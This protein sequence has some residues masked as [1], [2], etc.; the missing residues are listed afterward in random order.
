VDQVLR[1]FGY[2]PQT[3]G[4]I[5]QIFNEVCVE[6]V[7]RGEDINPTAPG[8]F[9]RQVGGGRSAG[10]EDDQ[11]WQGAGHVINIVPE[12]GFLIDLAIDQVNTGPPD[13]PAP[14]DIGVLPFY[15][16]PSAARLKTMRWGR[17]PLSMIGDGEYGKPY[18][19]TYM[20]VPDDQ[21]YKTAETYTS[22]TW[23]RLAML[24]V[25][26]IEDGRASTSG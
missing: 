9:A 13:D 11:G 24:T 1:A 15:A 16:K 6:Q 12:F 22:I 4:V 19:L 20:G 25:K 10:Y 7:N 21:S 5:Y 14:R 17:R 2:Q 18:L 8:A 3:L 23:K 26:E